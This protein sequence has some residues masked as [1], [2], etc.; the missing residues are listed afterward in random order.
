MKQS[1]RT[2]W[3]E[4]LPTKEIGRRLGTTKDAVIGQPHR[5]GLPRRE[6]PIRGGPQRA[7]AAPLIGFAAGLRCGTMRRVGRA[8]M[9]DEARVPDPPRL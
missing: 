1:L 9:T 8:G 7:A 3:S 6:S 2:L 4:G 5:L